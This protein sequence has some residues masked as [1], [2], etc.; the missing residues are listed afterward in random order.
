MSDRADLAVELVGRMS[1]VMRTL[2]DRTPPSVLRA[3]A[4]AFFVPTRWDS[5]PYMQPM[6]WFATSGCTAYA[7]TGGCTMCDFGR[8]ESCT[9]DE[10]LRR[11][12]DVIDRMSDVPLLHLATPRS[13]FDDAETAPSLRSA[14]LKLLASRS[15]VR[16]LGIESRPGFVTAEGLVQIVEEIE[17]ARPVGQPISELAVGLGMEAFDPLIARIAVNKGFDRHAVVPVVEATHAAKDM[18]PLSAFVV[19]THV[20]LKPPLISER[21]AVEDAVKAIEWSLD[22]GVTHVIL[23]AAATKPWTLSGWLARNGEAAGLE[24]YRPPSLWSAI[25]VIR[26]LPEHMHEHVRIYGLASST[27]MERLAG[28]CP[29]CDSVLTASIYEFNVTGRFAA[30]EPMLAMPCACR[31]AWATSMRC[32]PGLLLPRL[33]S[34]I[35]AIELQMANGAM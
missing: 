25:E 19:E 23:M 27:E 24:P 7:A 14:V 30:F 3:P 1:A 17:A 28:G 11:L 32:E 2:R 29:E 35:D 4:G 10:V 5:A 33:A 31:D 8:G 16:A 21:E 9:S 20:L 15:R 22:N 34:A 13:F 26:S 6:V 12:G 18:H